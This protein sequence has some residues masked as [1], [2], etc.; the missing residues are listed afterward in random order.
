MLIVEPLFKIDKPHFHTNGGCLAVGYRLYTYYSGTD[1]PVAMYSSPSG[2]TTYQNP[3]VLDSRGEPSGQGI[4]A[5]AGH[6]Y[7][8]I[9]KDTTDSVVWS[10][11]DVSPMGIGEIIVE[12]GIENIVADTTNVDV[13]ISQDGKTAYIGVEEP[14]VYITTQY[15]FAQVLEFVNHGILPILR[16]SFAEDNVRYLPLRE[17]DTDINYMN[18]AGPLDSSGTYIFA[19]LNSTGWTVSPS[20]NVVMKEV[21]HDSTLSGKGISGNPL[22]LS[23]DVV[24]KLAVFQVNYNNGSYTWPAY[25]DVQ[26][27]L[28]DG[29]SVALVQNASLGIKYIYGVQYFV[30]N[31]SAYFY[32]SRVNSA[33]SIDYVKIFLDDSVEIGTTGIAPVVIASDYSNLTF[34]V[35]TGTACMHEGKR[36]VANT[37]IAT[38]EAWNS[39]HWTQKSVEDEIGNVEALLAAL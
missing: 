37:D 14:V 15:T 3:I 20:S 21:V 2:T 17:V 6:K 36:Y 34:P 4:Y 35:A 28:N 22:S 18:F 38:S 27:A 7:K 25:A 8:I 13:T 33:G 30:P 1:T 19:E 29:K 12:S 10:M 9:L 24:G 11:D 31:P 16:H 39:S 32:F 23:S 26:H 5:D